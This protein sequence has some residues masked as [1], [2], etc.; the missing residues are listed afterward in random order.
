MPP[1]VD[2][3]SADEDV[4]GSEVDDDQDSGLLPPI[5][6]AM[7]KRKQR[8]EKGHSD[9]FQPSKKYALRRCRARSKTNHLPVE[10]QLRL[11]AMCRH[12]FH[13]DHDY[14]WF[15]QWHQY[16]QSLRHFIRAAS[17]GCECCR[18]VFHFVI[19]RGHKGSLI[20]MDSWDRS[21]SDKDPYLFY[22]IDENLD[23][24]IRFMVGYGERWLPRVIFNQMLIFAEG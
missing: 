23:Y 16:H 4:G 20:E 3:S 14:V 9:S 24:E 2:Y 1:L 7:S 8:R 17:T 6:K 22:Q 12:I 5:R 18:R 19:S 11:C 10:D 13:S 15:E 21:D